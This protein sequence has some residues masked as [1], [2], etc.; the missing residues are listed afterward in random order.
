MMLAQKLA[1]ENDELAAMRHPETKRQP[2]PELPPR[3]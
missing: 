3:W 2:K 1:L